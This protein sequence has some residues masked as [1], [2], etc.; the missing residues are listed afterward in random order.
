MNN[1]SHKHIAHFENGILY[2]QIGNFYMVGSFAAQVR[3]LMSECPDDEKE[4]WTKLVKAL[5]QK[6]QSIQAIPEHIRGIDDSFVSFEMSSTKRSVRTRMALRARKF[7]TSLGRDNLSSLVMWDNLADALSK[8]ARRSAI[9]V[10][11]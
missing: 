3:A 6:D 11:S 10:K 8:A 1:F 9:S 4:T 5:E 2:F 7:F